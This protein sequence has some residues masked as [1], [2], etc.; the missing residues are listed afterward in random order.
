MCSFQC[1][2]FLNVWVSNVKPREGERVRRKSIK[3]ELKIVSGGLQFVCMHIHA[4]MNFNV[5]VHVS[6]WNVEIAFLEFRMQKTH[7]N[8]IP[9]WKKWKKWIIKSCKE[10]FIVFLSYFSE[11]HQS[12]FQVSTKVFNVSFREGEGG[13]ARETLN[14]TVKRQNRNETITISET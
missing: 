12:F 4:Q 6:P 3:I 14:L 9:L 2:D 10:S 5:A 11:C 8:I 13:G 7:K 1:R